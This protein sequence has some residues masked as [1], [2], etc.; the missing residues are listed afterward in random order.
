[1]DA[2]ID[3]SSGKEEDTQSVGRPIRI[4]FAHRGSGAFFSI[5]E[6]FTSIIEKLGPGLEVQEYR[7]PCNNASPRSLLR[8]LLWASSLPKSEVVHQTGDIHYSILAIWRTPVVLTLHDLRFV[9]EACGFRKLLFKWLWV[10]LPCWRA[11][12]ITVISDSTL[13]RLNSYCRISPEKISVIP[14][15]VAAEFVPDHRPWPTETPRVLLVGTTPNKNVERM[16]S[17]CRELDVHLVI[18]GKLNDSQR[19]AFVAAK[20]SF[21]E[22]SNL[23][24]SEVVEL[25]QSCDVVTFVSTYEGFGLPIIE[26]Q[27][28]GKPVLTSNISPMKE[29]ASDGALLVDPYEVDS[30]R[31]GLVRILNEPELRKELV[32]KGFENVQRFTADAVASQYTGLYRKVTSP[33][34]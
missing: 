13:E 29:V 19:E 34:Q 5:E 28:I 26:G 12:A 8:N 7:A 21:E 17:A 23:A 32:E 4:V 9:E 31:E 25:Y 27:A 3:S 10:R 6:L 11:N 22:H 15:C 33:Q 18:L 14:N 2:L 30:I 16:V 1:M 24:R 20:I